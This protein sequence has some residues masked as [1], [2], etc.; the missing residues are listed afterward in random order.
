MKRFL[1]HEDTEKLSTN[2]C[3]KCLTNM[4]FLRSLIYGVFLYTNYTVLNEV[5]ISAWWRVCKDLEGRSFDAFSQCPSIHLQSEEKNKECQSGSLWCVE[6]RTATPTRVI[7]GTI[8]SRNI[9]E[10]AQSF[11]SILTPLTVTCNSVQGKRRR[12]PSRKGSQKCSRKQ[13]NSRLR[14]QV[15]RYRW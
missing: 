12:N 3:L 15:H 7:V 8:G 1:Q 2:I 9:S 11:L 6:V 13:K 5:W 10:M 14:D 4:N